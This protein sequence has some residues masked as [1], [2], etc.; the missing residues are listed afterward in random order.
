[1]KA[2][3]GISTVLVILALSQMFSGTAQ[4]GMVESL[5]EQAQA[6]DAE[7]QY[8]VGRLYEKGR[9]V[10]QDLEQALHWYQQAADQGLDKAQFK[11]GYFYAQGLGAERDIVRALKWLERSADQRY[12]SAQYHLGMVYLQMP[13]TD[14]SIAKAEHWLTMA[15]KNGFNAAEY[16]LRALAAIKKRHAMAKAATTQK[17]AQKP[18]QKPAK[19]RP[20]K[21]PKVA[22]APDDNT[23]LSRILGRS[24]ADE[25]NRPSPYLPSFLASCEKLSK[26]LRCLSTSLVRTHGE[27][28]QITYDVESTI[29]VVT[30]NKNQ[31]V[32]VEYRNNV[33]SV[34][35]E[36]GGEPALPVRLGWQRSMHNMICAFKDSDRLEC[37]KGSGNKIVFRHRA[38][39]AAPSLSR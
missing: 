37:D 39:V 9:K 3:I 34:E 25:R 4:A 38:G 23:L 5:L 33:V 14:D 18:T 22:T 27:S 11:V 21:A 7:K 30:S 24:W 16:R 28:D 10:E 29:T 1:M 36:D 35:G 13:V 26:S 32:K 12:V 20:A 2:P 6:G 19:K 31:Q 15:K 8:R 17:P